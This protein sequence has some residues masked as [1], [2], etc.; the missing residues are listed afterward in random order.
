MQS[1]SEF[2]YVVLLLKKIFSSYQSHI[3]A[4]SF[5]SLIFICCNRTKLFIFDKILLDGV[6]MTYEKFQFVSE[7]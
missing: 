6:K 5:M 3:A 4:V 7:T 1:S 2:Q